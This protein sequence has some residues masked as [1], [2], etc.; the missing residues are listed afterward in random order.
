MTALERHKPFCSLRSSGSS[1]TNRLSLSPSP[2]DATLIQNCSSPPK[3]PPQTSCSSL[4]GAPSLSTSLTPSLGHLT[5]DCIDNT[6]LSSLPSSGSPAE[7]LTTS[8]SSS[9]MAV[10]ISVPAPHSLFSEEPSSLIT[11]K[12]TNVALTPLCAS[13]ISSPI[14]STV[15]QLPSEQDIHE[16]SLMSANA[17]LHINSP[18]LLPSSHTAP[19]TLNSGILDAFIMKLGSSQT[20]SSSTVPPYSCLRPLVAENTGP[21]AQGFPMNVPQLHTCQFSGNLENSNPPCTLLPSPLQDPALQSLSVSS[22]TNQNPSPAPAFTLKP[23]YSQQVTPTCASLLSLLTVPSPLNIPQTTSSSSEEPLTQP[24]PSLP[25]LGDLSRDL[26]LSE[27]LE[28]ND[29]I[30]SGTSHL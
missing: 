20:A 18:A 24:T 25:P 14:S 16:S 1:S 4:A 10:P 11:S 3:N 9:A 13:L 26:S 17:L 27:L 22:Q 2:V 21:A 29:W 8:S 12:P 6:H 30:L 15:A 23:S 19:S 7:L 5:P 28:V